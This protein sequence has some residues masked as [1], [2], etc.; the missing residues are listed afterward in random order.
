M[1]PAPGFSH[2][3]GR[4]SAWQIAAVLLAIFALATWMTTRS[5]L[6]D[7]DEPRFSQAAVEMVANGQW[8]FPT[9]NG[10]LRPD[11]PILIY[12][13]M[14][15]PISLFGVSEWAVRAFAPLGLAL[16]A[17]LTFL[18][19]R[20]L[21]SGW[22]ALLAPVILALAPLARVEGTVATADAVLLA[23][24]TAAIVCFGDMLQRGWTAGRFVL[25]AVAL[26]AA[27][28]TTGPV[29]WAVPM[30]SIL[31]TLWI[32][33]G[34]GAL[35]KGFGWRLS[36]AAVASVLIFLAWAVPAN[37]ATAGEFL[38]RGLGKHV[39]SRVLKPMEGHGSNYLLYLF[40]Y[41]PVVAIG[42]VPWTL[43][44]PAALVALWRGRIGDAK[45]RALLL[46]WTIAPFCLMSLVAT[47]LAHYVMP[48]A[49]ALALAVAATID[50][51]ERRALAEGE[52]KWLRRGVWF[53]GVVL[54]LAVSALVFLSLQPVAAPIAGPVLVLAAVVL[55]QGVIAIH[56]HR[57]GRWRHGVLAS[58]AGA[59]AIWVTLGA[60]VL[61]RVEN[62][63]LA[64][65]LVTAM[66]AANIGAPPMA[67][68]GFDEPSLNFYWGPV[69]IVPLPDVRSLDAWSLEPG[70]GVL[71]TTRVKLNEFVARNGGGELR[72]FANV[73]GFNYSRGR[74]TE[75]VALRRGAA[76]R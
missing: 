72:E 37:E 8:L 25:L 13:L 20:R 61:P 36:I 3:T 47:K 57:R 40:Y 35:A 15:I 62:L 24:T 28:L 1:L 69:T 22:A 49:P 14:A 50:A 53:Y 73:H 42:F 41:V 71:V 27:Q 4:S 34:K 9:F 21:M 76:P 17:G 18:V 32:L 64:P 59:T 43:Q 67:T 70:D 46:G 48:I 60:L 56:L 51:A 74:E 75:V 5:T 65:R 2:S 68:F 38:N 6:W 10:E 58:I 52:M 33:R 16:T 11:K 7:R 54:A 12:W 29:G 45:Q 55:I 63:K 66:R 30:L 31:L 39:G 44:L 26:G 23:C 19:A